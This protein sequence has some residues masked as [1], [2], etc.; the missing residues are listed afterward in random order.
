MF[1]I[2]H[3]NTSAFKPIAKTKKTQK[4][5]IRNVGESRAKKVAQKLLFNNTIAQHSQ[6][7]ANGI[8]AQ[9]IVQ[10]ELVK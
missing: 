5:F 7:L 2:S 3:I 9:F 8:E 10:I 4:C 6:A 1:N